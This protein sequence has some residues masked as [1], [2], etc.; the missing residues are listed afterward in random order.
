MSY[1]LLIQ[2]L[3]LIIQNSIH[4][5]DF[6]TVNVKYYLLLAK[7]TQTWQE[8]VEEFGD[9]AKPVA[10]GKVEECRTSPHGAKML[11]EDQR[12]R[13]YFNSPALIEGIFT[14]FGQLKC[15]NIISCLRGITV[16]R[17]E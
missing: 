10:W 6:F 7:F 16:I 17:D 11:A 13:L 5:Q 14:T 12:L 4:K 3:K 1:E 2:N 9:R 15:K 8:L